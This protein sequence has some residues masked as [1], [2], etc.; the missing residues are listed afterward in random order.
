MAAEQKAR[1]TYDYILSL[2]DDPDVAAPIK[3][4]RAREVV[5][6]QRFGECLEFVTDYLAENKVFTIPKP[7]FMK[8]QKNNC[9]MNM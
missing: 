8:K 9:N 6:F 2:T 3:F 7:D 5:H 4:L 1:S